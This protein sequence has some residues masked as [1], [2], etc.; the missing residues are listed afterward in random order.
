M[1]ILSAQVDTG[2]TDASDVNLA[3]MRV[4]KAREREN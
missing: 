2:C 4:K 3:F 1:E